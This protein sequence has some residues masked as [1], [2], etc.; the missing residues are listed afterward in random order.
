MAQQNERGRFV[1]HE[2]MTSNTAASQNFYRTVVGW[3]TEP[4][5]DGSFEYTMWKANGAPV[6]G[7]MPMMQGGPPALG[8]ASRW[9]AYTEVPDIDATAALVT[10]LGGTI[11]L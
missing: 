9:I 6:G 4:M 5:G 8:T 1:W 2:L 11:G 7:V 10:K 3:D